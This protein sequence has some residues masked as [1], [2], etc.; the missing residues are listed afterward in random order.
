MERHFGIC[1]ICKLNLP[2][3]LDEITEIQSAFNSCCL[4]HRNGNDV[5]A[6]LVAEVEEIERVSPEIQ[7]LCKSRCLHRDCGAYDEVRY[8]VSTYRIL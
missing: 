5:S 1:N 4:C 7:G 6:D 8:A 2:K 3:E